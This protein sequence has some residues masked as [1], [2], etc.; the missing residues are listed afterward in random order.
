M[1]YENTVNYHSQG[2]SAWVVGS[3]G[4]L[5]ING[6][7]DFAGSLKANGVSFDRLVKVAKVALGAAD[8]G[9]GV[10]SWQN[11]EAGAIIVQRIIVDVTTVATGACSVSFGTT[12]ASATTSSANL[13]DTL[14]VHSATG[15]FDNITDGSTNGKARQKLAAGKWV[16]GSK[17][18][19]AAAG[20]VGSVY[21]EYIL[22]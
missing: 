18:S 11:P 7:V 20:L 16:T 5:T 17:A 1:S 19:G 2:G 13:I 8:T 21:I 15:T 10:L 4:T 22:A 3:G 12:A 6:T 14:D 9:G